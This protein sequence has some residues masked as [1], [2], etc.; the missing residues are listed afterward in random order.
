[1]EQF[2]AYRVVYKVTFDLYLPAA[3][4][5]RRT[6]QLFGPIDPS[7]SSFKYFGTKVR[8]LLHVDPRNLWVLQIEVHL[9]KLDTRSWTVLE[10]TAQDLGN[11]SLTFGIGGRTGTVGAKD[12]ILDGTNKAKA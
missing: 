7:A 10:K 11:I 9:K 6:L 12:I 8:V 3:K 5:F 4:R 1:V 2:R